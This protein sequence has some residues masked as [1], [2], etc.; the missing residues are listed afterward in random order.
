[1]LGGHVW[2]LEAIYVTFMYTAPTYLPIKLPV[3]RG[4]NVGEIQACLTLG[5][6][7]L[8]NPMLACL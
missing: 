6:H 1:M 8:V 4:A 5:I 7:D 2:I 3:F